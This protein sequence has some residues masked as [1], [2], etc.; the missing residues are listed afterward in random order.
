MVAAASYK[1]TILL[2]SVQGLTPR[3]I[4]VKLSGCYWSL[5]NGVLICRVAP[6][7]RESAI[8]SSTESQLM[9]ELASGCKR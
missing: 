6:S 8:G 3:Q 5:H 4:A 1:S 9:L 7:A 2:A